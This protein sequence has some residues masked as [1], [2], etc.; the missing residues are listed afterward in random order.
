MWPNACIFTVKD[1]VALSN[2]VTDGIVAVLTVNN[3]VLFGFRTGG[4]ITGF[5]IRDIALSAR[6]FSCDLHTLNLL[7]F[8]AH[9]RMLLCLGQMTNDDQLLKVLNFSLIGGFKPPQLLRTISF[10][11]DK[12]LKTT[13]I[14]VHPRFRKFITANQ[15]GYV[16]LYQNRNIRL[17]LSSGVEVYNAKTR[18]NA[19]IFVPISIKEMHKLC[20]VYVI[21]DDCTV[22][23]D[24]SNLK[25]VQ[26]KM[27]DF[28]GC[29]PGC[30]I[31]RSFNDGTT[32]HQLILAS[33]NAIYC[34]HNNEIQFTITDPCSN[35]CS[36][37]S[38]GSF[39]GIVSNEDLLSSGGTKSWIKTYSQELELETGSFSVPLNSTIF[40][41]QGSCYYSS[42]VG[43]K[44]CRLCELSTEQKIEILMQKNLWNCA[45]KY[46][47]LNPDLIN[48]LQDRFG[49]YLRSGNNLEISIGQYVDAIKNADTSTVIFKLLESNSFDMLLDFVNALKSRNMTNDLHVWLIFLLWI[50][51]YT[52]NEKAKAAELHSSAKPIPKICLMFFRKFPEIFK[53]ALSILDKCGID[54]SIIP[55]FNENDANAPSRSS[56]LPI[57]NDN[58]LALPSVLNDQN[59]DNNILHTY[60]RNFIQALISKH[61][62]ATT[63]DESV[64]NECLT[65]IMNEA[66]SHSEL[67]LGLVMDEIQQIDKDILTEDYKSCELVVFCLL[68]CI[69]NLNSDCWTTMQS[70]NDAF[71]F[72]NMCDKVHDC[73]LRSS[74]LL[75][76]IAN[77]KCSTRIKANAFKICGDMHSEVVD[78]L[79][80]DNQP[81]AAIEYLIENCAHSFEIWK[82]I[83]IGLSHS[84]TTSKEVLKRFI[85]AHSQ[86]E[87]LPWTL[88]IDTISKSPVPWSID[89]IKTDFVNYINQEHSSINEDELVITECEKRCGSFE[90]RINS[91]RREPKTFQSRTCTVCQQDLFIPAVHLLCLHSFHKRS[92]SLTRALTDCDIAIATETLDSDTLAAFTS[93]CLVALK[94]SDGGVRPISICDVDIRILFL[95]GLAR[96]DLQSV[97]S[98]YRATGCF[99]ESWVII[100]Y[101]V[102]QKNIQC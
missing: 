95:F 78:L 69:V 71:S 79:L 89:V 31:I 76:I 41:I 11:K 36:L 98:R 72:I 4:V 99:P 101:F 87:I 70:V 25:N 14:A 58:S 61:Q 88:V 34:Y 80:I 23:L 24:I 92:T 55:I 30:A 46:S 102:D 44:V 33:A 15:S 84:S 26:M 43:G 13:A 35:I 96:N 62:K 6:S 48:N 51:Q 45:I 27:I 86:Y 19:I 81:E 67:T 1:E 39:F 66:I 5:D 38:F 97:C 82:Q 68:N 17:G 10:G 54:K 64:L 8:S 90:H 28:V 20:K 73:K 42:G 12:N 52:W 59:I 75:Y 85:T 63:T 56:A 94:K 9:S 2:I 53:D 93:C 91:L 57:T 83:M 65:L 40:V 47:R 29:S 3:F 16:Y 32:N 21:T 18:V 49:D 77:E 22:I 50:K 100:R 37:I 7:A 74:I 60:I